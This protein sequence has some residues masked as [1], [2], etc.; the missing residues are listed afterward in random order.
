MTDEKQ[1]KVKT[2]Q[3]R[4]R[5]WAKDCQRA[6]ITDH[7]LILARSRLPFD[8]AGFDVDPWIL[9]CPN[10]TLDLRT[11]MLCPHRPEDMLTMLA[12]VGF[13]PDAK[14]PLWEAFIH[15]VLGGSD[16]LVNFV[17]KAAGYSLT[18]LTTEQ[19]FFV[20][21]GSGANGKST[22]TGMLTEALGDYGKALPRGLLTAQ[23]FEG[24]PTILADLFRVRMSVSSEVKPGSEWDGERIKSITGGDKIKARRMREDFWE[25]TATHKIWL[26]T[27]HQPVTT[28]NSE[29][30]Y[31]R[32]RMIPFT[33]TIPENERDP[34][35]M[36]KLRA[37]LPGILAWAVRGCLKWQ[38]EGLESPEEVQAATRDYRERQDPFGRFL[39]ECC[40]INDEV[41]I[42][43]SE[44]LSAYEKWSRGNR[45]KS[46]SAKEL[47]T[48]M[49]EKG[50]QIKKSSSNYYLRICLKNFVL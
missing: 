13:D 5:E 26:A 17:Q 37:E 1:I 36:E 42:Q 29:G 31:R 35:L 48:A 18:G 49:L 21:Y 7:T 16:D 19:V 23:K 8:S 20:L 9:N 30:F 6:T 4:Y 41:R 24:H 39:S 15:R 10:G 3:A 40:D 22:F 27:N 2:A 34:K 32:L 43:A 12:G 50:F 28:D 33:V 25:F 46:L 11:G 14:A 38:K 47:A 45:E 44:L